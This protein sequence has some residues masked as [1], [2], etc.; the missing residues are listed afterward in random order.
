[1]SDRRVTRSMAGAAGAGGAVGQPGPAQAAANANA[2]AN[3]AA[4]RLPSVLVLPP[5]AHHT[6]IPAD[7][8]KGG[9]P[10]AMLRLVPLP[11]AG[12]EYYI[13]PYCPSKVRSRW[14]ERHLLQHIR[15]CDHP[16]CVGRH[17]F[18]GHKETAQHIWGTHC[19]GREAT[20]A[21]GW[22][23]CQVQSFPREDSGFWHVLG[24]CLRKG[25]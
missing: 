18:G 8:P 16:D 13:C 12:D 5:A 7:F 10:L 4:V 2:N 23:G 20:S 25:A 9:V 11:K 21:C 22:P 15:E 19:E 17:P 6:N 1:M 14:A 3:A 24:H